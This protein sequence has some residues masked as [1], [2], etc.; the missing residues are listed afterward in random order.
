MVRVLEG[1]SKAGSSDVHSRWRSSESIA[2]YTY[3]CMCLTILTVN[4]MIY[5]SCSTVWDFY[6][7]TTTLITDHSLSYMPYKILPCSLLRISDI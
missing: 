1:G 2:I 4:T 5:T 3:V 6:C 7:Y